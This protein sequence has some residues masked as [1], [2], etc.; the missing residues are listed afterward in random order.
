MKNHRTI[1]QLLATTA[2]CALIAGCL[3]RPA[4]VTTRQFVLTPRPPASPPREPSPLALGLGAIKLPEY[5]LRSSLAV[6]KGEHEI[7]Y[8]ENSLWAER[9][10]LSFQRA[11]AANLGPQLPGS[12]I[13]LSTWLGNEVT[14][15]V[16]VHV[17][18]FDVDAQGN[19]TLIAR[20]RIET[21]DRRQVLKDG[22]TN[23]SIAGAN[24][25]NRP[26]VIAATLSEL[27]AQFSEGLART[28]REC[29]AKSDSR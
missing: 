14:L 18:R 3:F 23:L 25:N 24:P 13:Q 12:R 19:G 7:E 26:E 20:W 8:L 11:V 4:N 15:A 29:A 9:L 22:T 10:D 6:R 5:L 17:D 16:F 2:T 1:L 21:P 27:T 28:I